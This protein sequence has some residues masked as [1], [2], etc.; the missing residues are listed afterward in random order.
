NPDRVLAD[1]PKP[2][3]ELTTPN[4]IEL[5][6]GSR[7]GYKALP[8]PTAS[9]LREALASLLDRMKRVPNDEASS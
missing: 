8:T 2:P 6:V 9:G 1:I 5:R 4:A 7:P 3:A